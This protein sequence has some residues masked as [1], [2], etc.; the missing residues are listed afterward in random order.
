MQAPESSP[1]TFRAVENDKP[2]RFRL[3]CLTLIAV[4]TFLLCCAA[5]VFGAFMQFWLTAFF[6]IA[7]A[8]A[9]LIMNRTRFAWVLVCLFHLLLAALICSV[10]FA[11]DGEFRVWYFPENV[12]G[13]SSACSA[14]YL[15]FP[16]SRLS[17]LDAKKTN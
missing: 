6:S 2:S 13:L 14:I 17:T 16:A 11:G 5:V 10:M 12:L 15:M 3:V 7:A 1:N 9:V 4:A 8:S